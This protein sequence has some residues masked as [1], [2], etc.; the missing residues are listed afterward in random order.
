[1]TGILPR[2]RAYDFSM[3]C[4]ATGN[5]SDSSIHLVLKFFFRE[6]RCIEKR[7]AGG[8]VWQANGAVAVDGVWH[9]PTKAVPGFLFSSS[10]KSFQG[11]FC[12]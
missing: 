6:G 2:T 10:L 11:L 3:V 12:F 9:R 7:A 1:M 5:V 4:L 8:G